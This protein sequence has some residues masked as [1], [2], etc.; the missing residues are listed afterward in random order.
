MVDRQRLHPV[1]V[2]GYV[3]ELAPSQAGQV[4]VQEA[5]VFGTGVVTTASVDPPLRSLAERLRRRAGIDEQVQPPVMFELGYEVLSLAPRGE[6]ALPLSVL[7]PVADRPRPIRVLAL[8][9]LCR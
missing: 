4:D 1:A 3:A 9:D 7:M 5:L 8:D 2:I 6:A